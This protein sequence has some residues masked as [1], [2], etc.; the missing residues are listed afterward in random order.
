MKHFYLETHGCL[1]VPQNEG[2]ELDVY[3]SAQNPYEV[4]KEVAHALGIDM[5]RVVCKV[6]RLG[7][8]FGGKETKPGI[9]AIISAIAAR[10]LKQPVRVILERHID[11]LI[12]GTR[13]PFFL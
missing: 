1:V 11:M 9:I 13:H 8:G 12:T 3:S 4:Q 2:D 7:G 5:N 10:K 6:K